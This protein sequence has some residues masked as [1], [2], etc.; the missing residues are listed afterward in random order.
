MLYYFKKQ[1]WCCILAIL[2]GFAI[3]V[4]LFYTYAIKVNGVYQQRNIFPY[5][6]NFNNQTLNRLC[7]LL[8]CLGW[9][10]LSIAYFGHRARLQW[11]KTT[12]ILLVDC[13]PPGFI[14]KVLP[15]AKKQ[16]PNNNAHYEAGVSLSAAYLAAGQFEDA[17]LLLDSVY[18]ALFQ[19]GRRAQRNKITY[20]SNLFVYNLQNNDWEECQTLLEQMEQTVPKMWGREKE[21]CLWQ[22]QADKCLYDLKQGR[23]DGA[24][25]LLNAMFSSAE[26][27]L[28]RVNIQ[29]T[30]GNLYTHFGETQKAREA[31]TY[32]AQHGNCL[33][34]A[35]EARESLKPDYHPLTPAAEVG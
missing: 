32:A 29:Y 20:L 7:L 9:Y 4:C 22:Y 26:N 13:D 34:A 23:F 30:L 33:A 21:R 18:M 15:F 25:P 17:K 31:F 8:L 27:E 28:E 16:N 19:T 2:I 3:I 5:G 10:L 1:K 6:V 24:E 35:L 11:N 12:D 14:E